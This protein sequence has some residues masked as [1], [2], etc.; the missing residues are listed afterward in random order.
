MTA[1]N[2]HWWGV[3]CVVWQWHAVWCREAQERN[4]WMAFVVAPAAKSKPSTTLLL[5]QEGR[6]RTAW[7][8]STR[9][10]SDARTF[11]EC[12]VLR[13]GHSSSGVCTVDDSNAGSSF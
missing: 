2:S 11:L 12:F 4:E 1:R 5:G 9:T 13:D 3:Y 8:A 10:S 6:Q 7:L